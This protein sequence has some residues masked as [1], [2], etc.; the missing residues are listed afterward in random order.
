M[1]FFLLDSE[2]S[3]NK[4]WTCCLTVSFFL[5]PATH[6]VVSRTWRVCAAG[7]GT[8]RLQHLRISS[9]SSWLLDTVFILFFFYHFWLVDKITNN[10]TH[11]RQARSQKTCFSW[12]QWWEKDNLFFPSFSVFGVTFLLLFNELPQIL[13]S[14]TRIGIQNKV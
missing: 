3:T 2:Y 5:T 14:V 7:S 9:V 13:L 12:H 1:Q 4:G 6:L 11:H 10:T 8:Q